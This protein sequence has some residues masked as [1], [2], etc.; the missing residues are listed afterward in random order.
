M[1]AVLREKSRYTVPWA[2]GAPPRRAPA[3]YQLR[4]TVS[5]QPNTVVQ[6]SVKV[7]TP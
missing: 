1:L 6:L 4:K 3:T 5:F 2:R 7:P